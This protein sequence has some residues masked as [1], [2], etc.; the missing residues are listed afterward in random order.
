MHRSAR[1]FISNANRL[2]KFGLL[3][4]GV[5]V[6]TPVGGTESNLPLDRD[7]PE[8]WLTYPT[9]HSEAEGSTFN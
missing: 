4:R 3:Q 8:H 1:A 7:L 5:L 9:L 2:S 6:S